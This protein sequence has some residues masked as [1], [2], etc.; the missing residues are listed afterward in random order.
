M[1]VTGQ[2]LHYAKENLSGE[3]HWDK[4]MNCIVEETR[5]TD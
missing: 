4:E 5:P 3:R 1:H 2:D